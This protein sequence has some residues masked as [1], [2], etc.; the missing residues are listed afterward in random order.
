MKPEPTPFLGFV[1]F[2][3]DAG[4]FQQL[5]Y[6]QDQGAVVDNSAYGSHGFR[7]ILPDGSVMFTALNCKEGRYPWSLRF[8]ILHYNYPTP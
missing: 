7:M 4:M 1:R 2:T 3:D 6:A 8:N 5:A